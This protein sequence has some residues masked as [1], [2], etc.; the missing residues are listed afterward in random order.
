MVPTPW[1]L[2]VA[3]ILLVG[4]R[5]GRIRQADT[6]TFVG[7]LEGLPIRTDD[8]TSKHAMKALLN[9][10][11]V[12][13]LLVYDASYLELASRHGLPIVTLNARPQTAA[14]AFG[15]RSYNV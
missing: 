7:L 9:L 3:N 13:N 14:A 12:Q 6:A 8:E 4:E 15:I 5:R 11:R 2:D 10:N 1:P